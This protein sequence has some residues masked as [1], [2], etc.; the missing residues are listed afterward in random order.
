[1]RRGEL[2]HIEGL[3][4]GCGLAMK[5]FA[6][7]G[8]RTYLVGFLGMVL[9]LQ[10]QGFCNPA[11]GVTRL[12]AVRPWGGSGSEAGDGQCYR[13]ANGVSTTKTR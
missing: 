8:S 10:S 3:A 7:P 1:M 13:R 11:W 9:I 6:V 12:R 4:A 5:L 2:I